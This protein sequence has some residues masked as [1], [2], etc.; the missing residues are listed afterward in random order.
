MQTSHVTGPFPPGCTFDV[1][2][3]R[4]PPPPQLSQPTRIMIL[5]ARTLWWE[6]GM[7]MVAADDELP[8]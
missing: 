6:K 3:F 5:R 8:V 1:V 2:A 7:E 4:P